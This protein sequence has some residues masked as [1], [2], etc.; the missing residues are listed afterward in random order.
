MNKRV[1]EVIEEYKKIKS[2][3]GSYQGNSTMFDAPTQD[4]D[5]L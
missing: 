1:K 4:S 5:D 3:L 2:P